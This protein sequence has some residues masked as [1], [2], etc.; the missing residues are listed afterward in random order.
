MIHNFFLSTYNNFFFLRTHLILT[1]NTTHNKIFSFLKIAVSFFALIL[2]SQLCQSA[3]SSHQQDQD[4]I[5]QSLGSTNLHRRLSEPPVIPPISTSQA[6][7][8]TD[9]VHN[10][11][12]PTHFNDLPYELKYEIFH[13]IEKQPS[14]SLVCQE[15]YF[16]DR[17]RLTRL[18]P[19]L[20]TTNEDLKRYLFSFPKISSLNLR[21]RNLITY[22]GFVLI[23]NYTNLSILDLACTRVTDA[24]L[25]EILELRGEQ[26][27]FINLACCQITDTG[28]IAIKNCKNLT[29]LNLP[30]CYKITDS[31]LIEAVEVCTKMTYLGLSMCKQLTYQAKNRLQ[32]INPKLQ[33]HEK[34]LV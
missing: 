5:Q 20:A 27:T 29:F 25:T 26:L 19:P 18:S 15:W 1:L 23:K 7:F 32:T 6:L 33:I 16:L 14:I 17:I 8:Q 2:N 3:E 11:L 4:I 21:R 10:I 13:W 31:A 22:E 12:Q 30:F 34:Q 9:N 28:L 24:A